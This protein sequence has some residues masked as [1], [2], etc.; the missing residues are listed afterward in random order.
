MGL[1]I[2]RRELD[3]GKGGIGRVWRLFSSTMSLIDFPRT[4]FRASPASVSV[5]S[6]SPTRFPCPVTIDLRPELRN[7]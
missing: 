7:R 6:I 2:M 5:A 1:R 4:R 3:G